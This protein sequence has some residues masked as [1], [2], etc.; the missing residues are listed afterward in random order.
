MLHHLFLRLS[1]SVSFFYV[2][3]YVSFRA[4]TAFLTSL[5][6]SLFTGSIFIKN[7]RSYFLSSVRQYVP[8]TH[9]LK[10]GTPTMGGIFI[11][12]AAIFSIL[13]WSNL[14]DYKIWTILLTLLLFGLIG[15]WD[16]RQKILYGTGISERKK[17]LAQLISS[18]IVVLFW[19][20]LDSPS[21]FLVFPIFKNLIFALG[22]F[23]VLWGVWVM[24]C[25]TNG[26]NL[27]DG[28]DGLAASS[29][30]CN[31]VTFGIISYLAGHSIFAAYLQ[32]PFAQTAEVT[33]AIAALVGS[34]LGFLWYNT[35]PAQVFMGDIGA[36]SLGAVLALIALM[37]KQELLLPISGVLFVIEAVSVVL[38][39]ISSKLFGRRIFKMAPI[40]HH[41]ELLGWPESKITVRFVILT[42]IFCMAAL[43]MLKLR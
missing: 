36:L 27:T 7:F 11:L 14:C 22:S 19:Y 30:I 2:V 37:S 6:L 8:R 5:I 21:N 20:F 26:V 25:T 13:L 1:S 40:H 23:F 15:I 39:L 3:H 38:Q 31:F 18:L 9:K 43:I 41:F 33:V 4:C 32:I 12:L 16:D 29:L 28:L 10:E 24:L 34:L 42:L 17:F 35:Y